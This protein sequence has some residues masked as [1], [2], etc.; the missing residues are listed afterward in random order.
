MPWLNPLRNLFYFVV[1]PPP[2]RLFI[3]FSAFCVAIFRTHLSWARNND[4]F[5]D[6]NKST[7]LVSTKHR[8]VEAELWNGCV[9]I[10][11]CVFIFVSHAHWERMERFGLR[12]FLPLWKSRRKTNRCAAVDRSRWP[13][14]VFAH[15]WAKANKWARVYSLLRNNFVFVLAAHCRGPLIRATGRKDVFTFCHGK[16]IYGPDID[17]N[18]SFRR[19]CS[20]FTGSFGIA[21]VALCWSKQSLI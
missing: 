9:A 6:A 1:S 17:L 2:P 21:M 4:L 5:T 14:L 15:V 18:F 16:S 11:I 19:N 13:S 7:A 8:F 10:K 20:D 12:R 3:D